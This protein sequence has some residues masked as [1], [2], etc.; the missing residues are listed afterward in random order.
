MF[1]RLFESGIVTRRR[2]AFTSVCIVVAC[3]CDTIAPWG[4]VQA[5]DRGVETQSVKTLFIWIG[6]VA[7]IQIVGSLGRFWS[8]CRVAS[9]GLKFEQARLMSLFHRCL[10]ADIESVTALSQGRSMGKILFSAASERHFLQAVLNQGIPLLVTTVGSFSALLTLSV[11]LT[12]LCFLLCP[13]AGGLWLWMRRSLRPAARAEFDKREDLYRRMI[14]VFR[15]ITPIRAL[16]QD[17]R[18]ESEFAAS[19]QSS[20]ESGYK[21]EKLIAVQTPYFDV[22]QAIAV[23]LIFGIGGYYA[24]EGS[25]TVGA[26]VGFQVYLGRLF[27]LLRSGTGLFSAY[28]EYV[29]GCARADSIDALPQQKPVEFLQSAEPDVLR[30]DH[31]NFSFGAHEVWKDFS[32]CIAQGEKKCILSPSGSGKTTL[33]RCILGLYFTPKGT[34]SIPDGDSRAIGFVPQ[35]ALLFEGSLRSNIGMLCSDLTDSDYADLL[36]ICCLE[37]LSEQV[38][39]ANIGEGGSRL[40]GGEQRRVMLARALANAPKLLIIDQM[41]S[42][43]EPELCQTIFSRIAARWPKM[44]ILY[45]GH[46]EPEWN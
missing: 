3:L 11:P 9:M 33:A 44:G 14:D 39:D 28:Q 20:A 32:I 29:E 2:L 8:R 5:I 26:I 27:G 16:H 43:I 24:I 22:L 46:R 40:S 37:R 15:A 36:H 38:G 25:L 6:I 13:C 34:I 31:L 18:F 35:D 10:Y 23:V 7:V 41:T 42:E 4:L 19:A 17:K 21:L 30:V 1:K 12:F 45:L